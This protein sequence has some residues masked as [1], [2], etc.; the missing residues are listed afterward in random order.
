MKKITLC[1]I[2]LLS[3]AF[4]GFAKTSPDTVI[5]ARVSGNQLRLYFAHTGD[6]VPPNPRPGTIYSLPRYYK[7]QFLT[8]DPGAQ[9]MVE[10]LSQQQLSKLWKNK[11][12]DSLYIRDTGFCYPKSPSW[13]KGLYVHHEKNL[14]VEPSG[15]ITC[16]EKT[17]SDT[18]FDWICFC[19]TLLLSLLVRLFQKIRYVQV[20]H[21]FRRG[22]EDQ[23]NLTLNIIWIVGYLASLVYLVTVGLQDSNFTIITN[24]SNA[25]LELTIWGILILVAVRLIAGFIVAV[26]REEPFDW[27]MVTYIEMVFLGLMLILAVQEVHIVIFVLIVW[28]IAGI[29]ARKLWKTHDSPYRRITDQL[30]KK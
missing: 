25:Q 30:N 12:L 23:K 9:K 13:I 16:S 28:S 20:E 27:P 1:I 14:V 10:K 15:V 11:I 18:Y 17:T 22:S 4:W 21:E 6:S 24:Y 7:T 5:A 29:A 26:I 2:L 3:S 19:A 8:I